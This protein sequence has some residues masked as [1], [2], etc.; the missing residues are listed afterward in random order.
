MSSTGWIVSKKDLIMKEVQKAISLERSHDIK[1]I[2]R[3]FGASNQV[4]LL[5]LMDLSSTICSLFVKNF[6]L[7]M[8]GKEY[9][10]T[11]QEKLKCKEIQTELYN[12][13]VT[14]LHNSS[15]T[16]AKKNNVWYLFLIEKTGHPKSIT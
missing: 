10:A 16:L 3:S 1:E 12:F 15:W 14:E 2:R 6:D 4:P 9:F 5:N 13:I 7:I 8:Q 11:A